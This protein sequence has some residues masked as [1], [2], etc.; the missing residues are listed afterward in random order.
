MIA[1]IKCTVHAC[2]IDLRLVFFLNVLF[3]LEVKF[4]SVEKIILWQCPL[5]A[6]TFVLKSGNW[7]CSAVCH[8]VQTLSIQFLIY[9]KMEN[10]PRQCCCCCVHGNYVKGWAFA[11]VSHS[12]LVW[13]T[14]LL[15]IK[16]V[17]QH[18]VQNR[19]DYIHIVS[20]PVE[21][22]K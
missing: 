1:F 13:N 8:N 19:F 2:H 7:R 12:F 17:S 20:F 22:K 15:T 9:D 18:A 14:K 10:K 11:T 3:S 5:P 6:S 16:G 4:P 21:D